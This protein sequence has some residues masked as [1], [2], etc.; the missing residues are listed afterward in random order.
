MKKRK[1]KVTVDPGFDP[2]EGT[3]LEAVC[4]AIDY[5]ENFQTVPANVTEDANGEIFVELES[6]SYIGTA[7]E[8]VCDALE[9]WDIPAEVTEV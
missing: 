7:L 1:F 5:S 8:V 3:D 9:A 4:A 2:H 6:G